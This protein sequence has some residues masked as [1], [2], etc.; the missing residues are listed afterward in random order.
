MTSKALIE[1]RPQL[2]DFTCHF[3]LSFYQKIVSPLKE[4]WD[5]D[6]ILEIELTFL[7]GELGEREIKNVRN[8]WIMFC[9]ETLLESHAILAAEARDIY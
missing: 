7:F 9:G 2:R 1:S 3:C 6:P 5:K 4:R 8:L